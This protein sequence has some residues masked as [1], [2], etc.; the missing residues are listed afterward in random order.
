MT[1]GRHKML[2]WHQMQVRLALVKWNS[3]T[4]PRVHWFSSLFGNHFIL[5]QLGLHMSIPEFLLE[6][7]ISVHVHM[8]SI[9]TLHTTYNISL[10]CVVFNF[11]FK[12]GNIVKLIHEIRYSQLYSDK[13]PWKWR[14][15]LVRAYWSLK[16]DNLYNNEGSEQQVTSVLVLCFIG[17]H[18]GQNVA[19][20]VFVHFISLLLFCKYLSCLTNVYALV[21]SILPRSFSPLLVIYT[22][23]QN[24]KFCKKKK[25]INLAACTCKSTIDSDDRL[26]S[27]VESNVQSWTSYDVPGN[28]R[29]MTLFQ[30]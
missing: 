17:L 11:L 27:W 1:S 12:S 19:S 20:L 24:N 30:T 16:E 9:Y 15:G 14:S 7:S 28:H 5:P 6:V 29:N 2:A 26:Y 21:L 4:F 23:Y 3:N 22:Q 13:L 8:Y 25:Y 18:C 10:M